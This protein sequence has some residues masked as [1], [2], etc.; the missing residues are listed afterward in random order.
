MTQEVSTSL[1]KAINSIIG[2]PTI[3]NLLCEGHT[4]SLTQFKESVGDRFIISNRK[5]CKSHVR[6]LAASILKHGRVLLPIIIERTPNNQFV[7][8][9]GFHRLAA[10]EMIK[11]S[12]PSSVISAY[13]RLSR[14]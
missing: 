14:H 11:N 13:V 6:G 8:I 3:E 1:I 5:L 12:S 7:V 4:V 10:L 2:F 9:D